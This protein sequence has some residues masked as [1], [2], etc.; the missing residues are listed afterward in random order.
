MPIALFVTCLA[1]LF[2][3]SVGFAALKLLRDAGCEVLVPREQTCCG[4][5]AYNNGDR[6]AARAIGRQ[7]IRTFEG[8]NQVVVPSGSCAGMLRRHYPALFAEIP[9]W[10]E[11]AQALAAR[12]QE[13]TAFLADRLKAVPSLTRFDAR[14]TY[15]DSCSALREMGVHSQPR[16][17]LASVEGLELV[18]MAET[19]TCCGFG[20][21]FCVKFPEISQRM[22]DD[23][24]AAIEAAGADTLVAGDLGCL[25]NIAGRLSRRG[26]AVRVFHVAEVLAGMAKGPGIG[27]APE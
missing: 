6:E 5:P 26:S 7:V 2:R 14:A 21:T 8:Y 18:E 12:T 19:G 24:I 10:A 27:E 17:L 3:P 9:E 15:H 4:Q 11:R 16:R 1:D 25:L 23:K 20:G 22:V 13:L